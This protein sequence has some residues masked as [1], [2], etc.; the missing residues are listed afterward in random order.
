MR[1]ALRNPPLP[2]TEQPPF[3]QRITVLSEATG[4]RP[5]KLGVNAGFSINLIPQWIEEARAGKLLPGTYDRRQAFA[6]HFKVPLEWLQ[7][8]A[9]LPPGSRAPIAGRPVEAAASW[10]PADTLAMA[11]EA[12]DMLQRLDHIPPAK[13]W[14]LMRGL[15]PEKPSVLAFYE[16]ARKRLETK[17]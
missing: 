14:G 15:R 12:A 4:V 6:D 11:A 16:E 8:P 9:R 3:E 13:A 7:S 17:K 2:F 10:A 5:A 1:K